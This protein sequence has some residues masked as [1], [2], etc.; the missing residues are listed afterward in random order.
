MS[1]ET[2]NF[3]FRTP[4]GTAVYINDV[5]ASSYKEARRFAW[6]KAM[7][8]HMRNGLSRELFLKYFPIPA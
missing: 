6:A 3:V 8:I 2:H 1:N 7:K 4:S 5:H